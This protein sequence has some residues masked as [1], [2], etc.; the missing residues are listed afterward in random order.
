MGTVELLQIIFDNS[1]V[2]MLLMD[3][4]KLITMANYT[5]LEVAQLK[6]GDINGLRGGE[7]LRC[8]YSF[9]TP[10]G[11]GFGPN[12]QICKIRGT[13]QHTFDTKED[14]F[15]VETVF[16][17]KIMDEIVF[18][19]VLVSTAFIDSPSN[20]MVL[21]AIDDITDRVTAEKKVE[22]SERRLKEAEHIAQMGHWQLNLLENKLEWS[23]GV[24]E[25]FGLEPENFRASYE[26][27][28]ETI[29][30]DD[31]DYVDTAY[32][33]AL[34]TK[35]TYDIEHRLLLKNGT[36]KYVNEKCFTEYDEFGTPLHSLGTVVDITEL[37]KAEIKLLELNATKDK[38]FSVLAHDLKNPFN[39]IL[40]LSELMIEDIR[41]QQSDDMMLYAQ[42]I[43]KTAKQVYLLLVNLLDWAQIQTG[44][45]K[46]QLEKVEMD[47]IIN[48]TIELENSIALNKN[49][50][51][52]K[53]LEVKEDVECGLNML[54]TIVR[55][56]LSNAI[57]YTP[58][59]GFIDILTYHQ[60]KDHIVI[61]VK[62][63]GIGMSAEEI[64]RLFS[65]KVCLSKRGTEKETGTGLGLI[66]CKEFAERHK[67]KI[68]V[69]SEEGKGSEFGL[70][71]PLRQSK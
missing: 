7:A 58:K 17:L 10:D 56:L 21:V 6:R 37:K 15:K 31:R 35:T 24:Y 32:T 59:G 29:H 60:D 48:D 11:C 63:N 26:A 40:G 19:N 47:Q 64:K 44:R 14:Q 20:E 4:N 66:V 28:L 41:S 30:P 9:D 12:C 52:R 39:S 16:P 34:N 46:M 51:I 36:I 50:T 5:A 22:E 67:G 57:K 68:W 43:Q 62:D 27:F 54:S 2:I 1:P 23:D 42:T 55:N 45:I 71:I 8:A 18:R 53:H 70:T 38:L 33:M 3:K 13:V 25:I 65:M 61:S 49:I 69:K